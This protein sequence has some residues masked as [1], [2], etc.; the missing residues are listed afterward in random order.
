MVMAP[1]RITIALES[2]IVCEVSDEKIL[3]I[4]EFECVRVLLFV[5]GQVEF[6]NISWERSPLSI[7]EWRHLSTK[8]RYVPDNYP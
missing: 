4:Q 7:L 3:L 1:K 6:Q 2:C 5:V 8:T